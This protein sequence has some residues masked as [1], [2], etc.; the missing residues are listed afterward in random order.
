MIPAFAVV[1]HPNKGKSSVVS[2]LARDDSIVIS[3]RSGTTTAA[4]TYEVVLQN[5]SYQL[6][7][8]PGF[9]RP[10]KVLAWLQ[11]EKVSA[12]KRAQ[13]VEDFLKDSDWQQQ[14]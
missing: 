7:D 3:Q 9:Q 8:T 14:Y 4:K 10:R 12:D 5:L 13:R 6:I 2:T 1:G 11:S